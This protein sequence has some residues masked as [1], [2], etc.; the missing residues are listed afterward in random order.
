MNGIAQRESASAVST[1]ECVCL[2][3]RSQQKDLFVSNHP[4]IRDILA[5]LDLIARSEA[6]VLIT[7]ESGTGKEVIA[8]YIH[9]KSGK[10]DKPWVAINCAALPRDV[11]ENELFGH[12][13]EAYT[14]AL[15]KRLGCF[16]LANDGTLFLDEIA[17]MHPQVQ[18]KLLRAIELKSFRR[19]GGSEETT[20]DVR[21]VA[22]TNRNI[23]EALKSGALRE[24]L[25]Y[26]LSVVEIDLPPLRERQ[27]DIALLAAYF[28]CQL[29]EKYGK[30]CKS[31]SPDVLDTLAG[32]QWPGNVRELRN[33]IES[34]ILICPEQTIGPQFLPSRIAGSTKVE[35]PKLEVPVGVPL[36]EV[37]RLVIEKNL[38]ALNQNKSET[39]RV[40][41]VSRKYLYAK[42]DEYKARPR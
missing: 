35:G 32:Y 22:A 8:R 4:R 41:G 21:I 16:E 15:S 14:G 17:E 19:V 12:E 7:G 11:I 42:L 1:A 38:E 10:K 39:A 28:S 26:R 30:S 27:S 33:T 37:E 6:S 20:V 5:N 3:K 40:L 34:L 24:D 23:Q 36:V 29:C 2:W 18:A 31:F 25:Y 13:K 9:R